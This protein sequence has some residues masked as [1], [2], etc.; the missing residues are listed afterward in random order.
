MTY[1][2]SIYIFFAGS[3]PNSNSSEMYPIVETASDPSPP[4]SK[5]KKCDTKDDDTE[6]EF[7]W[8]WDLTTTSKKR[9]IITKN[10]GMYLLTD[11][12]FSKK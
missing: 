2:N 7:N 1:P 6:A 5:K 11:F 3:A 8:D 4:T 9:K 10:S 12:F